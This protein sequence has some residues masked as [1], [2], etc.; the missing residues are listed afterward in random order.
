LSKADTERAKA[1]TACAVYGVPFEKA[2]QPEEYPVNPATLVIGAGIAGIQASLEIANG[3]QKVYLVEKTGTIGGHMAMF[4]KTFPTLDCAACI[5]TPKM[6]E[7]GQHKN[8]DLM[9]YSEVQSISGGPGNYTVKI[10]KKARR[11]NVATC[12]GCGTCAEK[13]PGKAASE[14]DSGTAM[15]KAIYIPFP[16]AVPNKYLI[17][18]TVVHTYRVENAEPALRFVR[19]LIASTLMKKMKLL[20]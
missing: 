2:A 4:D 12:I 20:K 16:Q 17:D 7:I 13:C 8:I 14:F 3:N 1:I 5:L 10:L 11:V 18:V 15:R 19:F 9:T 6:V